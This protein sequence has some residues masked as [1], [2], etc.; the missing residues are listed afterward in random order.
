[1][2][3]FSKELLIIRYNYINC[4]QRM[5]KRAKLKSQVNNVNKNFQG[6]DL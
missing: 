3:H 2:K 5:S 4:D 6:F 1:M